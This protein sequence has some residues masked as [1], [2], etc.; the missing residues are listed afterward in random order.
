MLSEITPTILLKSRTVPLLAGRKPSALKYE[1]FILFH[2]V[3]Q[4]PNPER[5]TLSKFPQTIQFDL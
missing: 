1:Y 5:K 2:F 3:K 4:S